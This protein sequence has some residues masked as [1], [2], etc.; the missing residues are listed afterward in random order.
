ML[1][2]PRISFDYIFALASFLDDRRSRAM[3]FKR[4][5]LALSPLSSGHLAGLM[6]DVD[7]TRSGVGLRL[8]RSKIADR[9]PCRKPLMLLASRLL[10]MLDASSKNYNT[11][12]HF[13][14]LCASAI[15]AS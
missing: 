8:R 6:P 9:V 14:Y 4:A 1:N 2:T 10:L 12:I 15:L 11:S 5:V 13:R 7:L 3:L